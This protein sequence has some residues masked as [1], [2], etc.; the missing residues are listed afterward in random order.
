VCAWGLFSHLSLGPREQH[1]LLDLLAILHPAHFSV[2]LRRDMKRTRPGH[3]VVYDGVDP[4]LQAR[5]GDSGGMPLPSTLE[6][7][8]GNREVLESIGGRVGAWRRTWVGMC[9]CV[10]ACIT[11]V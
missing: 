11:Y 6:A 2:Q 7:R 4:F 8:R 10:S 1:V 3:A 5:G 9:V